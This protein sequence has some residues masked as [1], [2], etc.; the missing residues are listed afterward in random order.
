MLIELLLMLLLSSIM[1]RAGT[2][3]LEL[4][5]ARETGRTW[6]LLIHFKVVVVLQ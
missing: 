6:C 2:S 4:A 1:L 3:A 5:L